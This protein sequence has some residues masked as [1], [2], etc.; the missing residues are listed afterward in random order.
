[1]K[2]LLINPPMKCSTRELPLGIAHIAS[3]LE[4]QG[5]KD[6]A[7]FD[8]DMLDLDMAK[9]KKIIQ[10]HNP[11]IVGISFLTGVRFSAFE[12]AKISKSFGS[13]VIVGG[14]HITHTAKETLEG[15]PAIDIAVLGEGEV[16]FLEVLTNIREG[17]NLD[18]IPGI[19]YR[20]DNQIIFNSSRNFIDNLDILPQP[21][22][23]LLPIRAYPEYTLM[24][25]RG[26]W[27]D[28]IF[29]ESPSFWKRKIRYFSPSKVVDWAHY[30]IKNYGRKTIRFRDDY[31]TANEKWALEICDEIIKRKLKI[32][33]ECQG[34]VD[35]ADAKIF[36][37]MAE[38]GCYKISFGVE[39]G[40]GRILKLI[41]KQITKDQ[42]RNTI[43]LAR[44][45][46][47]R[48]IVT[49]FMIGHPSETI[50]DMEETYNFSLELKADLVSF[51]PADIF[52]GAKLFE[53]AK[54]NK[55]LPKDFS[56]LQK[57]IYNK[58]F[59]VE[60][61]V[62]TYENPGLTRSLL[63]KIS[64]EFF[65]RSFFDRLSCVESWKDLQYFQITQLGF[66]FNLSVFAHFFVYL[67]NKL[68]SRSSINKKIIFL[69][70]LF[71]VTFYKLLRSSFR[72]IK[73][74][75]IYFKA[76]NFYG[77]LSK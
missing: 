30:L 18:G 1:M 6:V 40:S 33:W 3:Y 35:L 55:V 56:W 50:P 42:V 45:A 60:K 53:I 7:I 52:P 58:G 21:A 4:S 28:C 68:K 25:T 44:K 61:D 10:K 49:F 63:E 23:H 36:K 16:T 74:R 2:I 27:G 54:E 67:K 34:R 72:K 22:W 38:A 75:F 64:R 46:G 69:L 70:L 24:G 31:F 43:N 13:I 66:N 51:K 8:F 14:P 29:C 37:R 65:M 73:I 32:R 15:I 11:D 57:G 39:A 47:F 17:K 20:K 71:F 76:N 5:F 12:I 26:C 48:E 19:A 41:N 59:C 77:F 9:I 62:P